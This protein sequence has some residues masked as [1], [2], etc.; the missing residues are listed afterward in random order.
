MTKLSLFALVG[1]FSFGSY[2]ESDKICDDLYRLS[3]APGVYDDGTGVA[4]NSS[5][6]SNRSSEEIKRQLDQSKVGFKKQLA[7]P[8]NTYFRKIVLSGTGLVLHP[9]CAE[10]DKKPKNSCLDLMA[11]G[12]SNLLAKDLTGKSNGGL[13]GV[14]LNSGIQ[15]TT[16]ITDSQIFKAEKQALVDRMRKALNQEGLEKKVKDKVFPQVKKLLLDKIE[17]MVKDPTLK[18]NL[19]EK[20]S[21]ITFAGTDCSEDFGAGNSVSALLISNAFYNNTKNIFKYCLGMSTQ[22]TSE[23]QM[24]YIIAHELAHSIDPCGITMGPSD[25]AFEYTAKTLSE[26]EK[27]FPFEGIASCLR[28]GKSANASVILA[29]LIVTP[30]QQASQT[31]PQSSPQVYTDPTFMGF[32]KNDQITES[33]ADWASAEILPEYIQANH[34]RLSTKQKR[35]GYSN[36]WRGNCGTAMTGADVHPAD[37]IRVNNILM[38]QPK[39]REQMN[40]PAKSENVDYCAVSS[41]AP[42][43][44]ALPPPEKVRKTKG[45]K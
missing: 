36:V 26:A 39:I 32:C 7:D 34:P 18:E 43:S 41:A 12:L 6:L 31:G 17:A 23:F 14:P 24:V 4:S 21:A 40:C 13:G 9:D 38:A 30:A 8:A 20:V 2:A 28:G 37:S 27:E 45:V 11:G 35:L 29:P 25:F 5:L 3:C 10:A 33:F 15:D 44:G 42:V 19:K 1:L 16:Y 22:N